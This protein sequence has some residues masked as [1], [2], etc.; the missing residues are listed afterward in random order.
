M[1]S[2]ILHHYIKQKQSTTY[3][4]HRKESEE[5]ES[6]VLVLQIDFVKNFNTFHQDEIQY[7]HW[8]KTQ[9]TMFT[10][11]LW[12]NGECLPAVVISNDLSRSQRN[13]Y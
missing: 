12:Q 1:P 7:A 13:L 8:N 2:F 10:A 3:L 9:I 11:A 6:D 5:G 4:E